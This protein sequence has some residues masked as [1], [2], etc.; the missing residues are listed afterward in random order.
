MESEKTPAEQRRARRKRNAI[1]RAESAPIE[2]VAPVDNSIKEAPENLNVDLGELLFTREIACQIVK[3]A[4]YDIKGDKEEEYVRQSDNNHREKYKRSAIHFLKS[5][6][7]ET[8][9]DAV[10]LPADRIRI[11]A[12]K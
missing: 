12:L 6:G 1:S 7:F 11:A 4:W 9:C 3:R 2:D 10:G 8:I 5:K